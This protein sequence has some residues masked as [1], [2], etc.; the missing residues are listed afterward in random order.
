[1]GQKKSEKSENVSVESLKS[2]KLVVADVSK[3]TDEVRLIARSIVCQLRVNFYKIRKSHFFSSL[4]TESVDLPQTT[5][6]YTKFVR[7][8]CRVATMWS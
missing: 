5:G 2:E 4:Q 8:V 7:N 6:N 1:M 3:K